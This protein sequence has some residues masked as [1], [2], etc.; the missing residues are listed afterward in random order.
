MFAR[1]SPIVRGARGRYDDKHFY[2]NVFG[3]TR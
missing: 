2:H 1:S 3:G